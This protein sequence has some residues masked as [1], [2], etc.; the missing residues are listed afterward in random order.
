MIPECRPHY[1]TCPEVPLT[2]PNKCGVDRIKRKHLKFHQMQCPLEKVECSFLEAG[3]KAILN[4]SQ[5]DEHMASHQQAHLLMVMKDYKETKHKLRETE[6]KLSSAI[7]TIQS[8]QRGSAASK[9]AIDCL[10]RL[11]KG[12]DS[13]NIMVPKISE[14]SRSGRIWYSP[15][16][17][18]R[19]GYKLCLALDV[20]RSAYYSTSTNYSISVALCLLKGEYD[21]QLAWPMQ[22]CS[23]FGHVRYFL[24][25]EGDR[26]VTPLE[27]IARKRLTRFSV[28][29]M[30]R[31]Q[32]HPPAGTE[33][34]EL[35]KVN[36]LCIPK[37]NI[38]FAD[39]HLVLK[40]VS[41]FDGC[42]LEVNV[43]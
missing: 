11:S 25:E 12:G 18:Y 2:C 8:L 6:V 38:H 31:K 13:V 22:K 10:Q 5:L 43:V 14:V 39:D 27:I 23:T 1:D 35:Q 26:E 4:R 17:F 24:E 7:A 16:F 21:Q 34:K 30:L 28:C 9:G 42:A 36:H 15:P 33:P 19:A 20:C 29:S 37:G 40:V 41:V 3:C 32:D